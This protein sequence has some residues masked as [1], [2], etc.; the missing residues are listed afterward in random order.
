MADWT[1]GYVTDI[2]Y[3]QAFHRE[4]TPTIHALAA[5][6][7]GVQAPDPAAPLAW[8]ELGC[9]PGYA[10]NLLAAANPHLT[11]EAM[12]FNPAHVVAARRLARAAGSHNI[13]FHDDSFEAFAGRTDLPDFDV[14]ALHG[15]LSWISADNRRWV[16]EILRRRLK[17]GGLVYVSYNTLPGWAPILPLRRLLADHAATLTGPTQTRV[18]AA[19]AFAQRLKAEGIGYFAANPAAADHLDTLATLPASYLAHEYFNADWIPFYSADVAAEMSAA[20]VT[21]LGSAQILDHLDYL[22]VSPGHGEAIADLAT[23]AERETL[24][25]FVTGQR[26]RRDLFIKGA[27]AVDPG[28]SEAAWDALRVALI[29]PRAEAPDS[30][31]GLFGAADLRPDI[32]GPILDALEAAPRSLAELRAD[33]GLAGL[34]VAVLREAVVVM[35]AADFVQPCLP[36]AGLAARAARTDAFNAEVL[37]QAPYRTELD[38][39]ASPVTGG[40]VLVDHPARLMLL[41]RAQEAE[42]IPAQVAEWLDGAA[43]LADLRVAHERFRS[44]LLPMLRTLGIGL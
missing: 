6:L 5:A 20:K 29:V 17:P 25:D 2:D 37:R 16:V 40:G 42:D 34:D 43:T 8:C 39:L 32:Y 9:G 24:R 26:F 1:D 38:T 23:S 7:R 15:V 18:A 14:I 27:T 12:D 35:I 4:L 11:I 19:L 22:N 3:V 31:R 13:R 44:R 30:V 21:W 41:A 36:V 10:A 33:P 28:E